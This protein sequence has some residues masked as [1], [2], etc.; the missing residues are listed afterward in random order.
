MAW[1]SRLLAQREAIQLAVK[2]AE[3]LVEEGEDLVD[4]MARRRRPAQVGDLADSLAKFAEAR[5]R[6]SK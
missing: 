5:R 1:L 6:A 4:Y 2:V 3:L